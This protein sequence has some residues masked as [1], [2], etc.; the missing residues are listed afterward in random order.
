MNQQKRD[1]QYYRAYIETKNSNGSVVDLCKELGT[2][3]TTLYEA[4][5]RVKFG[6]TKAILRALSVAR[7]DILWEH[8]YKARFLSLPENRKAGTVEELKE[9]IKDMNTDQ[10]TEMM[11]AKRLGKN[12]TTIRH[13]LG[14]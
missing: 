9:L 1:A 7:C 13:H 4:I 3:R 10:F 2:T 5:K 12:R 6:D 8:K 11:I 14:K